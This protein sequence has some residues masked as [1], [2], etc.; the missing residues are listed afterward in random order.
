VR[1]AE[2]AIAGSDWAEVGRLMTA[3]GHSSATD[4]DMSHPQVERIVSLCLDVPGVLGARMMGG[5]QG[6]SA[7]VLARSESVDALRDRLD[8]DY[9]NELRNPPGVRMIPCTFAPGAGPMEPA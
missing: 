2:R 7:L 1:D 3:S 6:G 8:R 9:F 4:Y 5:G